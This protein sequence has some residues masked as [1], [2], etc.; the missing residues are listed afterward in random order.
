MNHKQL[1]PKQLSF[2]E[3]PFCAHAIAEGTEFMRKSLDK[4][5]YGLTAF[6][7]LKKVDHNFLNRN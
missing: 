5:L 6:F 7:D 1:F 4:K 2:R 3:N